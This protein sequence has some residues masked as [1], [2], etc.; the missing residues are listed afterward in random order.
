MSDN[1]EEFVQSKR[2]KKVSKD[3]L[4]QVVSLYIYVYTHIGIHKIFIV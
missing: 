2:S 1:E 4:R 3:R